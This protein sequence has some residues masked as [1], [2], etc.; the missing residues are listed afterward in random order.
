MLSVVR[1][2]LKL[3]SPPVDAL[4]VTTGCFVLMQATAPDKAPLIHMPN[5]PD[6]R[7]RAFAS[8]QQVA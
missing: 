6:N 4:P 5:C 8:I 2:I 3:G 7:W 1:R